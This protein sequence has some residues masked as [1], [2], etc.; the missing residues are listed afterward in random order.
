MR[1][2]AAVILC[3]K[4]EKSLIAHLTPLLKRHHQ[5]SRIA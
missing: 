5:L 3:S 4:T 1:R 2:I